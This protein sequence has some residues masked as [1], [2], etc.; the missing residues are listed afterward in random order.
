MMNF[1]KALRMTQVQIFEHLLNEIP[2][3][4]GQIQVAQ[5]AASIIHDY[6]QGLD[7]GW[8]PVNEDEFEDDIKPLTKKV[9]KATGTS[10]YNARWTFKQFFD[11]AIWDDEDEDED[12]DDDL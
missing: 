9:V 2:V 10:E 11:G 1:R 12:D 8:G 7:G 5:K 3:F 6:I 4:P